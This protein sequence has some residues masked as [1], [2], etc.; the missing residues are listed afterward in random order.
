MSAVSEN[1]PQSIDSESRSLWAKRYI[2]S[3]QIVSIYGEWREPSEEVAL[4]RYHKLHTHHTIYTETMATRTIDLKVFGQGHMLYFYFLKYM[5][6]VFGCLSVCPGIIAVIVFLCGS[7]YNS[8]GSL[9]KSTI[10]NYGLVSTTNGT[11]SLGSLLAAQDSLAGAASTI[12]FSNSKNAE[13]QLLVGQLFHL[14]SNH[15]PVTVAG[16]NKR[17]TIIALSALDLVGCIGYFVFTLCF[18]VWTRRLAQRADDTT[19][20]IKDYSVRVQGVPDDV[21]N[22][23]IKKHFE[24]WGEVARVDLARACYDLIDM[25]VERSEI[26]EKEDR[27]LAVLQRTAATFPKV[28]EELETELLQCKLDKVLINRAINAQQTVHGSND[29]VEAYVVFKE[30]LSR[31]S[32]LSDQPGFW[33]RWNMPKEDRFRGKHALRVSSAPEPSDII[34]EN[35]ELSKSTRA[36]LWLSSWSVKMLLLLIGFVVISI[37]PAIQTDLGA[38]RGGVSQY[39]CNL[40]CTYNSNGGVPTLNSTLTA[41]YKQC[42][43]NGTL[44]NGISCGNQT[45]CYE[46]FCRLSLSTGSFTE[47]SYCLPFKNV[48]LFQIGAQALSVVAIVL[49]NLALPYLI[50]ALS[51]FERHHTRSSEARSSTQALL[52]M[53]FLNT[54]ISILVANMYLPLLRAQIADS[55]IGTFLLLGIYS[56]LTP[57]WYSAVGKSLLLSQILGVG[58]RLAITYLDIFMYRRQV[59]NRWKSLTQ[60]ELNQ[61]YEGPQFELYDRYGEHVGVV[62]VVMLYGSAMPLMYIVCLASF[63]SA[64]IVDKYFLLQVCRW[65]ITYNADLPMYVTNVLP[66][67][68]FVH[69][70]F[71]L[72]SFS[73]IAVPESG[74]VS[75]FLKSMC[76]SI[77][78]G[79]SNVWSNTNEFTPAQMSDRL[80]QA[81]AFHFLGALFIFIAVYLLFMTLDPIVKALA[82]LLTR[83]LGR[84]IVVPE[85]LNRTP[86]GKPDSPITGDETK[87]ASY[88][89][90]EQALDSKAVEQDAEE[91]KRDATMTKVKRAGFRII[92]IPEFDISVRSQLLVGPST[93]LIED[94]PEYEDAFA[95]VF[96]EKG[97]AS[98]LEEK[99]NER[100][101][102]AVKKGALNTIKDKK[103]MKLREK[104]ERLAQTPVTKPEV[105]AALAT[106]GD[107]QGYNQ[108]RQQP[109][110]F[111]STLPPHAAPNG[112]YVPAAAAVVEKSEPGP[113]WHPDGTAAEVNRHQEKVTSTKKGIKSTAALAS[114]APDV[115]QQASM[116]YGANTSILKMHY[117]EEGKQGRHDALIPGTNGKDV[118]DLESE[119]YGRL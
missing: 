37:A 36:S 58:T 94:V 89:K 102:R 62:F 41:V 97:V 11:D 105:R 34:Y 16:S 35:L 83:L 112:G 77:A 74:L 110:P 59:R 78:Y 90:S 63:A 9:E 109:P 115:Q 87:D 114:T 104:A 93:Y 56:D 22:E 65:P 91:E 7:W 32:C 23:E 92:G 49:V 53:Y 95:A 24:R 108:A 86:K 66:Y 8:S 79:A 67:A 118:A 70:L 111:S 12:S 5:A 43:D 71:A 46:C 68:A 51:A 48:A 81:D 113:G 18:I 72:W 50:S 88:W 117:A 27:A 10:G 61:A 100:E 29:I 54:A 119:I 14:D 64:Y 76:N 98:E 38:W 31:A 69:L 1:D 96:E 107:A 82:P 20:T 45:I 17:A 19:V 52:I 26:N 15:S 75:S 40:F 44:S 60:K 106:A 57:G 73:F 28:D 116:V 85:L 103:R 25:V 99:I 101:G 55:W 84:N 42:Y 30:E 80:A 13:I 47:L 39:E 4:E 33:H 3:S 21:N 6:I 2:D